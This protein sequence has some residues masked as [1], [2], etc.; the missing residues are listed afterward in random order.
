MKTDSEL[1]SAALRM[2]AVVTPAMAAADV[3]APLTEWALN[4][5]VSM[6]VFSI[7]DFS[8]LAKVEE[9]TGLC[10][11][12]TVKKC[13]VL[14]SISCDLKLSEDTDS[15]RSVRCDNMVNEKMER[16]S[17]T[18]CNWSTMAPP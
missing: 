6:P 5:P 7:M 2:S 11:L 17:N 10:G 4:M 3:V 16:Y 15:V 14:P 13:L 8:H 1:Q 18:Q 9:L 12:T